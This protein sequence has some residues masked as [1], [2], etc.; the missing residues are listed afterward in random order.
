M[1]NLFIIH[2]VSCV[3][4]GGTKREGKFT[5][6]DNDLHWVGISPLCGLRAKYE[7]PGSAQELQPSPPSEKKRQNQM[8]SA[9]EPFQ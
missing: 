2:Y 5:L 9:E 4:I 1:I 6:P 3:Q 8:A 7:R